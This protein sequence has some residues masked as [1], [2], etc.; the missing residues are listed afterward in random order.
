MT[1]PVVVSE[2]RELNVSVSRVLA[3]GLSAAVA[4]ML[5]GT[6]LE[7]ALGEPVS[8]QAVPLGRLAG[9]LG[10]GRP[11]AFQTLGILLLLATPFARV[12]VL[13][14]GYLRRGER[15]FAAISFL[16]LAVLTFSVLLGSRG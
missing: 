6:A 1:D 16:V 2:D 10:L 11:R 13:A 4:S 8:D 15:R 12:A 7:M 5:L 14:A 3:L 9:E